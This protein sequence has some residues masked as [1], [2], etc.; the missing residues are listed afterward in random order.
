MGG[1]SEKV[2]A[3]PRRRP[4]RCVGCG[5]E[6]SKKQLLRVVRSPDGVVAINIAGKAPGRGAYVCADIECIR[7]AKKRNAL[8]WA[9]KHAV[10]KDIYAQ[11]EE[12]CVE[13]KGSTDS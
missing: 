1:A 10:D 11:L 8:S 3:T 5:K 2:D 13:R 6:E 4:R 12:F 9:L 7:L